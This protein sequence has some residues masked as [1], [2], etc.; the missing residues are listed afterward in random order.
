MKNGAERVV[1]DAR[2]HVST[3]KI[4]RNFYYVEPETSKDVGVNVRTRAGELADLLGDVDRIRA[5][6]R[7]ARANRAK[8][9]TG[10]GAGDFAPGS[11]T[12]R[13]GGFSSDQYFESG[14]F[15]G[16]SAAASGL[17][18][19]RSSSYR[20]SYD[21]YDAGA[22]ERPTP[23]PA[24]RAPPR[25]SSSPV[26]SKTT[27]HAPTRAP[28]PAPVADLLNWDDSDD[29]KPLRPATGATSSAPSAA[30]PAP[31]VT[32]AVPAGNSKSKAVD[33]LD[34]FG[35]FADFSKPAPPPAA[36][37]LAPAAK[38][39]P[40]PSVV[41]A[42]PPSQA[43]SSVPAQAQAKAP[44]PAP[45]QPTKANAAMFDF[46]APSQ[47]GGRTTGPGTVRAG[48]FASSTSSLSGA[49][50]PAKP[51]TP[52]GQ[53]GSSTNF[54]DLWASAGPRT[55][56]SS[57]APKTMAELAAT[58]SSDAVWGSGTPAPQTS[59]KPKDVFDLL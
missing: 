19:T 28:G 22:D 2:M 21:E 57:K 38:P 59:N 44:A 13:F 31:A 5:E 50:T 9:A 55:T 48:S 10:G 52:S 7:K 27:P 53:P 58:K 6:R 29:D 26:A 32:P 15:S 37:A 42:G 16:P 24:G 40:S 35:D 8:F 30:V 34:D 18:D 36:P 56:T 33:P 41:S 54:D 49:G 51:S 11:G 25:Q 4:L 45:S 17:G 46:L 1:D 43:G 20:A 47:S 3:I 23:R 39:L 14:G 12:G